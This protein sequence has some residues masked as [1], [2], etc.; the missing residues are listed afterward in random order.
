MGNQLTVNPEKGR[1]TKEEIEK[2]VSDAER[3]KADDDKHKERIEARNELEALAYSM[4]DRI[5]DDKV[6][7]NLDTDAKQAVGAAV[8]KTI[9]WL[10]QSQGREVE[11]STCNPILSKTYQ[12]CGG[13]TKMPDMG[14]ATGPC[15]GE[16]NG[17]QIE[18]VD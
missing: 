18:E 5:N 12:N 16:S 14:S 7:A 17:P 2:M 15:S 4:R 9:E 1:L 11:K 10:D 13:S 3:Y 8:Q 6:A